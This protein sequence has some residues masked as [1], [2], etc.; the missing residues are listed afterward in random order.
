[1]KKLLYLLICV[2][3]VFGTTGAWA[4]E[5]NEVVYIYADGASPLFRVDEFTPNARIYTALGGVIST[6]LVEDKTNFAIMHN[7]SSGADQA[8]LAL[9]N[10]DNVRFLIHSGLSRNASITFAD[11]G[12]N[13]YVYGY[14]PDGSIVYLGRANEQLPI[15]DAYFFSAVA[16]PLVEMG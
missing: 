10:F 4:N 16:L 5:R 8:V 12:D 15:T 13:L 11:Y 9:Y 14:A 2:I 1:M 7:F 3:M 6:A